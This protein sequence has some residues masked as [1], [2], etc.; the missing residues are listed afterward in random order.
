[1]VG[2]AAVIVTNTSALSVTDLATAVTNPSRSAG[3]H[4]FNLAQ[5]MRVVE[6]VAALRT[7]EAVVDRRCRR[8]DLAS[9]RAMLGLPTRTA[10]CLPRRRVRGIPQQRRAGRPRGRS[11]DARAIARAS[12][13]P[14]G[15][16]VDLRDGRAL[17]ACGCRPPRPVQ[18]RSSSRTGGR[19]GRLRLRAAR[20]GG[21]RAGP[22]A[23]A[24]LVVATEPTAD[25]GQSPGE[26]EPTGS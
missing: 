18:G 23:G 21:C 10:E 24:N 8:R 4:F 3:L 6:T 26:W 20:S 7:D 5:L 12:P 15:R 17:R 2:E 9:M 25:R 19:R 13:R 14:P 22:W 1:M 16:T 11:G